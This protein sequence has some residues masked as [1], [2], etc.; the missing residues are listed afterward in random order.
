M[1]GA[2]LSAG[3]VPPKDARSPSPDIVIGPFPLRDLALPIAESDKALLDR[4][5]SSSEEHPVSAEANAAREG[6][7]ERAL[8]H[9]VINTVSKGEVVVVVLDD[10]VLIPQSVLD[11]S[12]I[13]LRWHPGTSESG[14]LSLRSSEPEIRWVFDEEELELRLTVAPERFGAQSFDFRR[15][16]PDGIEYADN[17]SAY[18]N[19][20]PRLVDGRRLD[21]FF[22]AGAASGGSSLYS[23]AWTTW[24][25]GFV[26]GLTNFTFD[27]PARMN[28]IVVG[29]S[30]VSTGPLGGAAFVGGITMTRSFELDPYLVRTPSFG[31]SDSV[32]T[33]STLEV[34]VNDSLVKREAIAP[35]PFQLTNLNVPAGAGATRYVI[36]D[37]FGNEQ[38]VSSSYY[39]PEGLLAP[40]LSDYA[41]SV[42]MRRA[43]LGTENFDY[44]A[45]PAMLLR[46]RIGITPML[47]IG[48]R[49]EAAADVASAGPSVTV[50]SLLGQFDAAVSGSAAKEGPGM[51]GS[52][53]HAFFTR[54]AGITTMLRWASDKYSTL[55]T[56][57]LDDRDNFQAALSGSVALS[58]DVSASLQQIV[59]KS[60]DFGLSHRVRVR[61]N[62]RLHREFSVFANASRWASEHAQPHVEAFVGLSWAPGSSVHA[63]A[64]A[65]V[66][67]DGHEALVDVSKPLPTGTGYGFRTS[68]AVGA[69]TRLH[70]LGQAQ[71]PYGRYQVSYDRI[72]DEDHT[73]LEAA[74]S[75]VAVEGAGVFLSRPIRHSFAVIDVPDAANVRGYLQN[76][77][78]GTTSSTGKLFVPDL[79]PY[80]GNR[81]GIADVDLPVDAMI[82][83]TERIVAPPYRGGAV[84]RFVARRSLFVRGRMVIQREGDVIVP[85]YGELFVE[86]E[87]RSETLPLGRQGEF[88][89]EDFPP[90][91]YSLT[92][93]H[94]TTACRVRIEVEE[95]EGPVIDVGEV[96]CKAAGA[97]LDGGES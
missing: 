28:R 36:R 52:L 7:G 64:T 19:Y 84:V 8:L 29:D 66:T 46:H 89:L 17:A 59:A 80:Y 48:A 77:E 61:S 26:R 15:T 90:G 16:A 74:G 92:I 68:A 3:A 76:R 1:L 44:G 2:Q 58:R 34:Y 6:L 37:A 94:G 54:Q 72:G 73:V 63:S 81:I 33:P 91:L 41:Y 95:S 24:E 40:G 31:F 82:D 51:A 75:I 79:L 22:E 87:E 5:P 78:V 83:S 10:D 88:E 18:L 42:G 12:G 50:G 86:N 38:Q 13:H 49:A 97:A 67:S 30:F 11:S 39:M 55:G 60:R 62:V 4:G 85:A 70:A 96:V 32:A 56:S 71:G 45:S 20:A 47:T 53:A 14:L 23:S 21:V 35:G 27:D 57:A 65:R 69:T 93:H 25:N 43:K 9:L